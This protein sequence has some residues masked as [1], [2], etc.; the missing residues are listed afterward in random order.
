M[1]SFD[2]VNQIINDYVLSLDSNSSYTLHRI[3]ELLKELGNP[4]EEFKTV[5]IAGTSGKTSTSY[6]IANML[7]TGG[8]KVGL[9]VSPYVEEMNE[10]V[11]LGASPL[12]EPIFCR[13][14][15]QF[16]K[17]LNTLSITPTYFELFVAFAYWYFA[18]IKVDYAV[19]EV[20]LGG[21]LDG[22]NVIE[23]QD[24]ICVITD[25]GLDHTRILGDTL[26]QIVRQKAG[27]IQDHNHVF[28]YRQD[29]EIGREIISRAK[30]KHAIIHYAEPSE[31][32]MELVNFQKRNWI[33]ARD[34][35]EYIFTRDSHEGLDDK[36]WV[37]TADIVIP[38]RLETFKYKNKTIILDGAHNPQK[39]RSLT[40]SFKTRYP[41]ASPVVLLAVGDNKDLHL[42]DIS[43][44]VG[45]LSKFVIITAFERGRDAPR[46]SISP[47][48]IAQKL[49]Q[50]HVLIEPDLDKAVKLLINRQEDLLLITGS[51]YL[52]GA[53]KKILRGMS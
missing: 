44:E 5:H 47:K 18:K 21:L 36:Q 53:V 46:M 42:E 39:I 24:K 38:G 15:T 17:I 4:Q 52:V 32:D 48:K 13:E 30:Q 3:K 45:K 40:E 51:L 9:S 43:K 19:I 25:I 35:C 6:Y 29:D 1:K 23:R 26:T 2:E 11:Q 16:F 7:K 31:A 37:K 10:R 27:I 22:T 34:V 12:P 20:G 49:E 50:N 8:Y 41:G 33:L 14:F 28:M